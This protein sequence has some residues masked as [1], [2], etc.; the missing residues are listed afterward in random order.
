MK[1]AVE[2]C[3]HGELDKIYESILFLQEKEGIKV[4]LLLCCGD[5][6][7]VRNGNDLEC[8]AVPPKYR[9]IESF[10]KYYSGE[11]VA[12]VLTIFIGGNHEASNHLWELPHG[13]WVAPNIYYLGYSGVVNFGGLRIAGLSGIYKS[14]DY[15]KGHY[16]CPPYDGNTMRSAYHIR[17]FDV[18]K[19]KL[20]SQP[21][22]IVMSHDWPQGV[23]HHGDVSKLYKYKGFLQP[24]IESNTLGSPPAMEILQTLQPSYWFSAHLHVK[25]PALIPH[26]SETNGQAK[27]TKFLALDKCLPH[28]DF[29]QVIDTGPD[30]APLKLCYDAEWLAILKLTNPLINTTSSFTVLPTTTEEIE[31]YKP[32]QE[33]AAKIESEFK[34]NLIIPENFVQT[35]EAFNPSQ[36]KKRCKIMNSANPQTQCLCNTLGISNSF[37]PQESQSSQADASANPDEIDLGDDDDDED[38][39]ETTGDE[40]ME[41]EIVCSSTLTTNQSN[42]DEIALDE[43]ILDEQNVQ[44]KSPLSTPGDNTFGNTEN[45]VLGS[46]TNTDVNSE[47]KPKVFKLCRRNQAIYTQDDEDD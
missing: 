17:S 20:L 14:H 27:F 19:L 42:P 24:E 18:F 10:Y 30:K 34:G 9:K 46:N 7:A 47:P 37:F 4:D 25:F 41:K 45:T 22:D 8:M 12:P 15:R 5:F 35:V 32:N 36:P 2:G 6:Q 13:G 11:K 16:E 21:M 29:L 43:S 38:N 39:D 26:E 23:Y 44:D 1:I 3:A 31:H 33:M 28:R 40:V